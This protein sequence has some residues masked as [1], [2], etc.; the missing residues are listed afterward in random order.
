MGQHQALQGRLEEQNFSDP[1]HVAYHF[2]PH[3]AKASFSLRKEGNCTKRET[4]T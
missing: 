3:S 2:L 4:S 1:T